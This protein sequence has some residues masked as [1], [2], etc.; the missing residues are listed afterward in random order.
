MR[1]SMRTRTPCVILNFFLRVAESGLTSWIFWY[2]IPV[3]FSS[4]VVGRDVPTV[5][6]ERACTTCGKPLRCYKHLASNKLHSSRFY[7]PGECL[8]IAPVYLRGSLRAIWQ[9]AHS[10]EGELVKKPVS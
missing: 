3:S 7:P 10:V 6:F 5:L 9:R 8:L 1:R 2:L 4:C